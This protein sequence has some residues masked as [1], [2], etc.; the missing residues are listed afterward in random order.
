M[1]LRV[2]QGDL[3]PV[4]R[5]RV[6]A[7]VVQAQS[8]VV[9]AKASAAAAEDTLLVQLAYPPGTH[10]ELT[11]SPEVLTNVDIDPSEA[12]EDAL[13]RN[14]D[15]LT[16]AL[17][18]Q[19][20]EESL[21]DAKHMRLPELSATGRYGRSGFDVDS[22]SNATSEMLSDSLPEWYIGANLSVPL[23][24]R[25]ARGE[26]M[27][28]GAALG[29]ARTDRQSAELALAQQVR[30]QVRTID[31][32]RQTIELAQANL[33]LAEETL[34]AEQALQQAGRGIQKDVLEALANVEDA[35]VTLSKARADYQL[36]LVELGRLRGVL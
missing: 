25:A 19:H 13:G 28:N 27:A 30:A 36:A 8:A 33:S 9:E 12:V 15:I 1:Q 3:A 22:A 35:R 24:N 10:V 2:E 17:S 4:E 32:A 5:A 20:A 11:T 23:A 26:E 6:A 14:P 16:L 18:E 29:K 21:R 7:A 34:A 31:T